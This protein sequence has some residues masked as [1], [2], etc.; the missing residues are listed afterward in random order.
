ME[1]PATTRYAASVIISKML[2]DKDLFGVHDAIMKEGVLTYLAKG[3][4][5]KQASVKKECAQI[6]INLSKYVENKPES[7]RPLVNPLIS[8]LGDEDETLVVKALDCLR[9]LSFND[10]LR[11]FIVE[12]GC[13]SILCSY[14]VQE[15]S[16]VSTEILKHSVSLLVVLTS[17]AD[18]RQIMYEASVLLPILGFL[19]SDDIEVRGLWFEGLKELAAYQS[20]RSQL[21]NAENSMLLVKRAIRQSESTFLLQLIAVVRVICQSPILLEKI[22]DPVTMPKLFEVY[23]NSIKWADSNI[24]I[25]ILQTL[26]LFFST[27]NGKQH[28]LKNEQML[29]Y[30]SSCLSKEN[31]NVANEAATL[32]IEILQEPRKHII[33]YTYRLK[34]PNF[35]KNSDSKQSANLFKDQ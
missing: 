20:F 25:Y 11:D 31:I 10:K 2:S 22:I 4:R 26:R 23:N 6:I 24:E 16:E 34:S 29:S 12:N 18:A 3:L 7:F 1:V 21:E 19:S 17:N 15:L 5:D 8:A 14:I 28:V 32:L 9:T 35:C 13:V 30:A 33:F 27:Q